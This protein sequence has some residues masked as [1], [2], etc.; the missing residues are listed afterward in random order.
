MG[1]AEWT[2][3][4]EV[5]QFRISWNQDYR[6]SLIHPTPHSYVSVE[7]FAQKPSWQWYIFLQICSSLATT[8]FT[9]YLQM[10]TGL[11]IRWWILL[12]K[13]LCLKRRAKINKEIQKH[14]SGQF[15][16]S[17][18]ISILPGLLK[19]KENTHFEFELHSFSISWNSGFHAM[20]CQEGREKRYTEK[21]RALG[22]SASEC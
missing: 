8:N 11:L 18:P 12:S 15:Q 5:P 1:R 16:P 4:K 13:A 6:S 19:S 9:P 21:L 2:R 20:K 17:V 14:S 22:S 7:E 10:K 3:E